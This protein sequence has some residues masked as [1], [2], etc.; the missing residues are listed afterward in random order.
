MKKILVFMAAVVAALCL[1]NGCKDKA[2]AGLT[3]ITSYAVLTLEGGDR[4]YVDK[5]TPFVDPGYKAM[6]QGKDVTDRVKVISDVDTEQS[7]VYT[8]NYVIVNDDGF[9]ATA[10]REVVVDDLSQPIEGYWEL[11]NTISKRDYGGKIGSFKKPYLVYITQQSDGSYYV[12]DMFAG[13]YA[14]QVGYGSAAAMPGVITIDADGTIALVKSYS[15]GWGDGIEELTNGKYD[16]AK[17]TIYYEA[18]F[19][20]LMV[21]YVTLKRG[22]Q[23]L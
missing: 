2:S 10:S 11:D 4:V 22:G 16:A 12:D 5:G 19:R 14:I 17:K 8:V 6:M 1:L 9:P 3:S 23:S 18:A 15:A 7:G 21:F 13:W 20:G